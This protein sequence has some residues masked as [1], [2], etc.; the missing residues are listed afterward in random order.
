VRFLDPVVAFR[1][2]FFPA[3]PVEI[4]RLYRG[5]SRSDVVLRFDRGLQLGGHFYATQPDMRL[6]LN[7][8][9][10]E[11]SFDTY[12]LIEVAS[13]RLAPG[14]LHNRIALIG[15]TG[16]GAGDRFPAP[17]SSQLPGVELL[18]TATANLLDG[19]I[20]ERSPRTALLDVLAVTLGGVLA[21]ALCRLRSTAVVLI[22][23]GALLG[24]WWITAYAAFSQANMW[25]NLVFPTAAILLNGTFVL[26]RRSVVE[27][28]LASGA[29]Q[30]REVLARF[31]PPSIAARLASSAD[32]PADTAPRPAAVMFVDLR[33]FTRISEALGPERTAGFLRQLHR[34]IE[35]AVGRWDGTVAKFLGDGAMILFG[36]P[37]PRV[38][39]PVNALQ[40]ANDLQREMRAWSLQGDVGEVRVGIGIAYG[41]I[42]FAQLGGEQQIELTAAGDTVNLASRLEAFARDNEAEIAVSEMLANAVQA[43]GREDLLSGFEQL[44]PQQIRGRQARLAVWVRRVGAAGPSTAAG[45]AAGGRGDRVEILE[46]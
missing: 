1:D 18:A 13:D 33:G 4:A 44:P 11:G 32:L 36:V 16:T 15:A 40:A 31:L 37:E 39:D 14:T 34:R 10:P 24:L 30:Q 20:L 23:S 9:G 12:P 42:S 43:A 25:L 27:H 3:L 7:F 22:G 2:E 6:P 8:Y 28:R 45:S 29:E 17:F 26:A 41:P 46:S 19:S 21:A 5:L 38:A 35:Q